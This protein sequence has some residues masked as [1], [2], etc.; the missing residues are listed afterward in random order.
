MPVRRLL[1]PPRHAAR[2]MHA[3]PCQARHAATL[4]VR[5]N[6]G[7]GV[8]GRWDQ[9]WGRRQ[10]CKNGT[11]MGGRQVVVMVVV[12]RNGREGGIWG[13]RRPGWGWVFKHKWE[14]RRHRAAEEGR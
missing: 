10:A 13:R 14:N 2:A 5:H 7:G 9:K 12:V 4:K 3:M 11:G 8:W 6:R 1:P